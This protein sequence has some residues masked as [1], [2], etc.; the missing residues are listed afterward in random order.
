MSQH[1]LTVRAI[2]VGYGYVKYTD[3]R[4]E[5][6]APIH[7]DSFPSQSPPASD[8]M[9]DTGVMER[10]DTF[11]V[12]INDRNY[13]VGKAATQECSRLAYGITA[14]RCVTPNWSRTSA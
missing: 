9:T 5:E 2:D 1:S 6:S 4:A 3:G 12:G 14:R 13:E 8:Q 7:T 11:V 10:R